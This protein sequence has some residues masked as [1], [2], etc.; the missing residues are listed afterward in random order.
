MYACLKSASLFAHIPNEDI[1]YFGNGAHAQTHKKGK[2]LYIE[3]EPAEF[4][5]VICS[6]WLKLF[7]TT[8]EGEEII[9]DMLSNSCVAGVETIFEDGHYTNNAQVAEDVQ[10]L[11]IPSALLKARIGLSPA[12]AFSMLSAMSKESSSRCRNIALSA[13]QN[14]TQRIAGFLLRLCPADQNKGITFHLPYDK[15]L[16]ACML[17]MKS[18]SFSRALNTLRRDKS[19]RIR[20]TCVEIDS[21]MKLE[22]FLY[23]AP[24]NAQPAASPKKTRRRQRTETGPIRAK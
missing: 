2:L 14:A 1:V 15:T 5:Y 24:R 18:G 19:I 8:R 17:R 16:I 13:Q 20:G 7:H 6:G 9:I 3:G 21:K 10:L 11:K 4:F 22:K 12:F 23:G